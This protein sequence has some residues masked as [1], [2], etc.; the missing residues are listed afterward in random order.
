MTKRHCS[1][2][3]AAWM[4]LAWSAC[5]HAEAF[6]DARSCLRQGEVLTFVVKALRI[7][8]GHLTIETVRDTAAGVPSQ[9]RINVSM[10][11][12]GFARTIYKYKN[13]S[14]S[15]VDVET[16]RLLQT[17]LKG[18]DGPKS[19]DRVTDLDHGANLLIHTDRLRP[20]KSYRVALPEGLV[21]L[22]VTLLCARFWNLAVGEQRDLIMAYEGEVYDLSVKALREEQVRTP[23]GTFTAVVMEPSQRGEPRGAFKKGAAFRFYVS[24]EEQP[25]VVRFDSLAAAVNLVAVLERVDEGAPILAVQ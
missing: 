23:L 24:R 10:A 17:Q 7:T 1:A 3:W 19:F 20:E 4:L 21:D 14:V 11:T 5:A 25:R 6:N 16:G 18:V 8:G 12:E 15:I 2:C 22:S 9:V 13:E